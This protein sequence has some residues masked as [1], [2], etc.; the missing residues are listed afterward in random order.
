MK[1]AK[2]NLII[3]LSLILVVL[4]AIL[5]CFPQLEPRARTAIAYIVLMFILLINKKQLMKGEKE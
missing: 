1:H 2:E 5:P 3:W 4:A